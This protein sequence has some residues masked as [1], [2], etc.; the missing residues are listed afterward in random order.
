MI[1]ICF[2]L[3]DSTGK[4]SKYEA[5]A[6]MS[7]LSNSTSELT[8]HI[9]HDDSVSEDIKSK[10]R[11]L[12]NDFNQEILFHELKATDFSKI[13]HM[14]K[15]FTIGTLFRLRLPDVL[16]EN[17]SKIIYLDADLLI[18]TNIEKIW[19]IDISEYYVAAC[20]DPGVGDSN[21]RLSDGLVS[22]EA[23][24]N[25]GVAVFN[26]KKIRQDFNLFSDCVKFLLNH[27]SCT[28]ADQDAM[29]YFFVD[30]VL[31]LPCQYNLFT[32]HKRGKGEALEDGI[33]HYAADYVC[34]DAPEEFD[35]KYIEYMSRIHWDNN[36]GLGGFLWGY[37]DNVKAKI[38][39]L[40]CLCKW[41]SN[42]NSIVLW[43]IGSIYMESFGEFINLSSIDYFVDNNKKVQETIYDGKVVRAPEY[44]RGKENT[45]IVVASKKYY[46]EIK[47]QLE[48]YGFSEGI[49]FID[50]F[51]LLH[52]SQGGR[53]S[54]Y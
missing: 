23:Y 8:V 12:C 1:H 18:N 50:G 46:G 49:D 41:L 32:R 54:Y 15:T 16:D 24:F 22:A 35:K 4:Y 13:G 20:H 42:N 39:T 47:K 6:L 45:K 52:Q 29:N 40:Q 38:N 19:N 5:V 37:A 33:Y 30:N 14:A 43:G 51:L 28:M 27:P 17:I 48:S 11:R 2:P 31:Y 36:T 21:I 26:L 44:L 34:L 3:Y 9:I 53:G 7:L 25:A 10:L